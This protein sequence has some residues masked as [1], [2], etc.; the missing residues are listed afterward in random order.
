MGCIINMIQPIYFVPFVYFD[1]CLPEYCNI[2]RYVFVR[3]FTRNDIFTYHPTS[4]CH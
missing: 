1:V 4:F 3:F 2:P